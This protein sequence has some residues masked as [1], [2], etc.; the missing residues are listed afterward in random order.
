MMY[1]GISYMEALTP[2]I[3]SEPLRMFQSNK[4]QMGNNTFV[5]TGK[6]LY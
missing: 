5:K 2:K 6:I 4:V 3:L 1:L